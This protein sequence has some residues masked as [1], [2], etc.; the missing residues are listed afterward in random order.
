[1]KVINLFGGPGSG[2]STS[3]AG[4]FY[5]MKTAN[6]KVEEAPEWIKQKVYEGNRYPFTD[7]LYVFAKQARILKQLKGKV[8]YAVTASP[9]LLSYIFAQERNEAFDKVIIDTFNGFDNINIFL[10]RVKPYQ[11]FGRYRGEEAAREKDREIKQLLQNLKVPF[12]TLEADSD[13]A[14]KL[15][16]IVKEGGNPNE[17]L[18]LHTEVHIKATSVLTEE[19]VAWYHERFGSAEGF[20][21]V[22]EVELEKDL[23][24]HIVDDETTID[25]TEIK[26]TVVSEEEEV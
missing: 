18:I 20:C 13:I 6:M 2:K 1:M 26:A 14:E 23:L 5:L 4:L 8:D 9:L 12:I 22:Y 17:K 21:K 11:Q 3:R 19:E 24:K 10:K 15:F 16:N 7:Q 25:T